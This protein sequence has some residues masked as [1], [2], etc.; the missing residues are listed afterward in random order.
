[1]RTMCGWCR[2]GCGDQNCW[3][4]EDRGRPVNRTS[5]SLGSAIGLVADRAL[6]EPPTQVHPVAGFGRL[7]VRL[8]SV[9]RA[10]IRDGGVAAAGT[11]AGSWRDGRLGGAAYAAAGVGLGWAAG[12]GLE[13]AAGAALG[14][15][16]PAAAVATWIVVAGRALGDEAQAI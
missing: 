8:E 9:L 2:C 1:M 5:V 4:V 10:G 7:M 13:W 16:V 15:S 12:V 11:R 6:G 3:N 14:S